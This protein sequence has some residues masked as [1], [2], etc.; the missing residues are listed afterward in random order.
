MSQRVDFSRFL[1][2][3]V[4]L[5][6]CFLSLLHT[7]PVFASADSVIISKP[8]LVVKTPGMPS[9]LL[10]H[11]GLLGRY[12]RF[13]ESNYNVAYTS[14]PEAS[15]DILIVSKFEAP[16]ESYYDFWM[17]VWRWFQGSYQ[18]SVSLP[19][20]CRDPAAVKILYAQETWHSFPKGYDECFDLIIGFDDRPEHPR[21]ASIS[22]VAYEWFSDKISTQYNPSNDLW[23]S[24]GCQPEQRKYDVCM[25]VSKRQERTSMDLALDRIALYRAFSHKV[26]TASGGSVDNNIGYTVPK[27][28]ELDWLMNCKFVIGYENTTYPGYITEKPYQAWLAGAIP[29]YSAH[30]SVLTKINKEAIVYAP[31]YTTHEEIVNRVMHLLENKE[32]YCEIWQQSLHLDQALDF[33]KQQAYVTNRLTDITVKKIG[34]VK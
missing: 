34:Q 9:S 4:R 23:R 22:G 13:L 24:A 27:G 31:D 25:L 15:A 33:D 18:K 12:Q 29:I 11:Q 21:Y 7:N 5:V 16:T 26:N 8:R 10:N 6:L 17:T 32:A 20:I 30:R 14:D 1:S 3:I 2:P 28:D 19:S